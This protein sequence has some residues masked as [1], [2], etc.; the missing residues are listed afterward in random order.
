MMYSLHSILITVKF[1][2]IASIDYNKPRSTNMCTDID[3]IPYLVYKNFKSN[4]CNSICNTSKG[5]ITWSIFSPVYKV[6][7]CCE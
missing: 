3:G 7:I 4:I 2:L 5:P 1:H 6:E